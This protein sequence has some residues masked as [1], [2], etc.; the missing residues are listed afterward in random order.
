HLFLFYFGM[1]SMVTPPVALATFA[2]ASIAQT[3][4]WKAGWAGVRLGI[5]AYVV[6]F[7]MVYQPAIVLE[8]STEE[9]TITIAKCVIGVLVLSWGAVGYLFGPAGIATRGMLLL[10]GAALML[11]P[12]TADGLNLS[13]LAAAS[14]AALA[15]IAIGYT[16]RPASA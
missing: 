7:V 9:I 1:M 14:V 12:G 13:V 10:S 8:G 6:P 11:T 2:A 4:L 16:R 5:V 3:D 15:T